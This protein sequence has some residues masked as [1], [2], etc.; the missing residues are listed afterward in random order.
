MLRAVHLPANFSLNSV[1]FRCFGSV[2]VT[3]EHCFVQEPGLEM[4]IQA[5][6]AGEM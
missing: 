1:T 3:A 4:D 5:G 2:N 6:G